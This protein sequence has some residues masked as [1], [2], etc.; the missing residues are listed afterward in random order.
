[1][2]EEEE[3]DEL[4]DV[5]LLHDDEDELLLPVVSDASQIQI[6]LSFAFFSLAFAFEEDRESLYAL[7]YLFTGHSLHLGFVGVQI[8]H[9]NSINPWLMFPGV[10]QSVSSE[11]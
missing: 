1:M 5:D 8:V 4:E 11:S 9:P 3:D 10:P 7:Q 6:N 2:F